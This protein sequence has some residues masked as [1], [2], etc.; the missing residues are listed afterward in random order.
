MDICTILEEKC[1]KKANYPAHVTSITLSI[2]NC[3]F[4]LYSDIPEFDRKVSPKMG[5]LKNKSVLE[6]SLGWNSHWL[7]YIWSVLG[8]SYV[9][10]TNCGTGS[11][12]L[13]FDMLTSKQLKPVSQSEHRKSELPRGVGT[14]TAK[15]L[16]T[17]KT[18]RLSSLPSHSGAE[19]AVWPWVSP[20]QTRRG[21]AET[22]G[23]SLP[24]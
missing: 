12:V 3:S 14:L 2:S 23:P 8:C 4:C 17:G 19:T 6:G 13:F 18:A 7:R 5:L 16:N 9:G 22:E 20:T 24:L 15:G 11:V 21:A 10:Q 1:H